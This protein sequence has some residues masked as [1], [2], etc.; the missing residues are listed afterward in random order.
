M[1]TRSMLR[2]PR[3]AEPLVGRE[4]RDALLERGRF[5]RE[6]DEAR[7]R[8]LDAVAQRGEIGRRD[9]GRRDLARRLAQRLRK[10]HREIRLI[11]GALGAAH[12]RIDAGML[13]PERRRHGGA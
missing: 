1:T 2:R 9:D 4:R 10:P 8:D 13:C 7:A 6:V 3:H 11:V 5:Q 12:H